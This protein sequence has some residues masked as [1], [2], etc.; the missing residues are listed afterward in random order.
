MYRRA[1]A[2]VLTV[3]LGIVSRLYPVGFPLWDH[4][5]GDALY[6]VAVYLTLALTFHLRTRTV[7]PLALVLCLLVEFFQAT[8]IPARYRNLGIVYWL[9][10]TEFSWHDIAC[11][12]VGVAAIT[13]LDYLLLREG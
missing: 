5:L 9:I 10:G 4:S 3:A 8:G 2:L 13:A 6:A 1:I 7:A 11:Y 12:C